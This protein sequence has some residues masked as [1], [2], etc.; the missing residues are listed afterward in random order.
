MRN[1]L[2]ALK[3][4]GEAVR[5]AAASAAL[6]GPG[7]RATAVHVV[8]VGSRREFAEAGIAVAETVDLLGARGVTARGLMEALGEGGVAGRLAQRARTSGADGVVMGSRGLGDFRALVAGSVSHALLAG[9]DLPVLVLPVRAAVPDSDLRRVLVAVGTE[10]DAGAAAAAVRLLR[11]PSTEVLA[12][13]VPRR[14]AVHAGEA[15]AG[16]FVE[17]GETSTAVLAAAL[18]RFK[19]AGMRIATTTVDRTGGVAAAICDT[20]RDWDADLIVLGSRRPGAWEA[21]AAGS[22]A[23]GVLHRSDRP[24]LI[25]G[26]AWRR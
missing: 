14:V 5:L 1:L 23:H 16:L 8:E 13:H 21:L 20:A 10:D 3:D 19:R 22:T 24:V 7:A 9:V 25:A 2:V 4:R 18:E 26:R 15:V 11:S 6:A 12:V 17:I